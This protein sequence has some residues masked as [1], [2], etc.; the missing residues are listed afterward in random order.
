MFAIR[1][2]P[3]G[4]LLSSS[5]GKCPDTPAKKPS[6][7]CLVSD[8]FWA[9]ASPKFPCLSSSSRFYYKVTPEAHQNGIFKYDEVTH[10]QAPRDNDV[11]PC[12][13]SRPPRWGR[14]GPTGT[15]NGHARTAPLGG[16][17]LLLQYLIQSC[18]RWGR[19][20]VED[21]GYEMRRVE[22]LC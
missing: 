6:A 11:L 2:R 4:A 19:R 20:I 21:M 5:A 3:V 12:E 9:I 22:G 16:C 14:V 7:T 13:A 18:A 1:Q 8:I 10:S 15:Q 17:C